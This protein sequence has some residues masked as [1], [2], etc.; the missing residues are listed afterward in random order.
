MI[1]YVRFDRPL[2]PIISQHLVKRVCFK[3]YL[4]IY[5]SVASLLAIVYYS[6]EWNLSISFWVEGLLK[7][8]WNHFQCKANRIDVQALR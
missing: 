4:Q 1:P 8:K 6:A 5:V 7:E 2:Y 3:V